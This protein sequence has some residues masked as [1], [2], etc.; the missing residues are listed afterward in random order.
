MLTT[1]FRRAAAPTAL[2]LSAVLAPA[3]T[4]GAD[5]PPADS[6][7]TVPI[8]DSV[9]GPK[10]PSFT[11]DGERLVF[12]GT[13]QGSTRSEI[14]TIREN[15]T[16]LTCLTCG[17]DTGSDDDLSQPLVF[18]DGRRM[19][20]NSGIPGG[21]TLVL[22]CEKKISKCQDPEVVPLNFPEPGEGHVL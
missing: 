17:L 13:P 19:V 14:M 11:P 7:R 22:E 1:M 2:A 21:G 18:P 8:P 5:E 15:G 9:R 6:L 4:A 20:V 12:T 3:A 16:G 10:F